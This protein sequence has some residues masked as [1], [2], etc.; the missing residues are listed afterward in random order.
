ML[1]LWRQRIFFCIAPVIFLFSFSACSGRYQPVLSSENNFTPLAAFEREAVLSAVSQAISPIDSFSGQFQITAS[2]GV[3]TK[4]FEQITVFQWP[5]FLRLEYRVPGARTLLA[6]VV[7]DSDTLLY[8]DNEKQ[9]CFLG[10]K[11]RQNVQRFV[12]IPLLPEEFMLFLVGRFPLSSS[13]EE[14]DLKIFSH[15]DGTGYLV[16]YPD[17]AGQKVQLLLKKIEP[18]A[19][20]KS[21]QLRLHALE[22][23]SGSNKRGKLYAEYFYAPS[24]SGESALPVRIQVHLP[25]EKLEVVVVRQSAKVNVDLSGRLHVLFQFTPPPGVPVYLLDDEQVR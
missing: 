15:H 11:T 18:I 10:E 19:E 12:Q 22:I 3:S 16:Q 13:L 20:N 17:G 4:R 2:Q 5:D 8:Y 14:R 6:L 25:E 21:P 9:R 23:L 7:V 24:D 1:S